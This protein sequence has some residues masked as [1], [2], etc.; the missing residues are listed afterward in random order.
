MK[1]TI[2]KIFLILSLTLSSCTFQNIKE[3]EIGSIPDQKESF[4]VPDPIPQPQT[5]KGSVIGKISTDN[6]QDLVGL[7][8]YLGEL[9]QLPDNMYGAYLD[10]K[11]S[12]FSQISLNDGTFYL[13]DVEPGIYSLIIYEV[14][15]GGKVYQDSNGSVIPIKV[16]DGKI[17]DV[18]EIKFSFSEI[19]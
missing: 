16:V 10:T 11:K 2:T 4:I 13:K 6:S 3:S 18:G 7:I 12:P 5:G 1:K 19:E 15:M 8:I 17:T 9:I 14:M